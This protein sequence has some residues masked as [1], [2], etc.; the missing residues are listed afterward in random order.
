MSGTVPTPI[1]AP[2]PNPAA[3]VWLQ[4][5]RLPVPRHGFVELVLTETKDSPDTE[6]VVHFHIE[7]EGRIISTSRPIGLESRPAARARWD[8]NPHGAR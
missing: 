2:L 3:P 5:P 4:E 7:P 6:Y 8:D 1:P